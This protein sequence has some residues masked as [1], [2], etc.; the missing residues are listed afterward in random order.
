MP[1]SSYHGYIDFQNKTFISCDIRWH[2]NC[3]ASF[4][5]NRNIQYFQSSSLDESKPD[6]ENNTAETRSQSTLFDL[7]LKCMFC[8]FK[9]HKKDT[10]LIAVQYE[11]VI[12]SIEARCNELQDDSLKR[13][14]GYDFSKLPALEAKYHKNCYLSY[15][16]STETTNDKSTVHDICFSKLVSEI[17]NDLITGRALSVNNLLARYKELLQEEEYDGFDSYTSQK[18]KT[19][20]MKYYG[21]TVC[22]TDKSNEKQYVYNSNLS[23]ADALNV[24]ATYKEQLKDGEIINTADLSPTKILEL[25]ADILKSEIDKAIGISIHPL[26]PDVITDDN[27]NAMI[28]SLLQKFLVLLC[29]CKNE[30]SNSKMW[31]IAQDIITLHSGGKKRMPKN[32]ALGIA[33]KNTL[34]SKEFISYLNNLGHSISYDDVLRIETTWASDIIDSGAGF[35]TIPH[36]IKPNIFTQA[37]SDNADYGQENTSQHVTNTVLY[38]YQMFPGNFAN[39]NMGDKNKQKLRLRR[40]I[41]LPDSPMEDLRTFNNASLPM[42]Y[43][44]INIDDFFGNNADQ[45]SVY[46]KLVTSSW[47]LLRITSKKIFVIDCPQKIPGWTGF[48]KLFSINISKPTVIG[49]CRTIPASPTDINVVHTMMVNVKKMLTSL[50]QGDPCLTVDE[51]IYQ[52]AKQV[53]WCTPFLQDMTIRLGGFHRAKNFLGIIGK[54]MRSTGLLNYLVKP[55]LKVSSCRYQFPSRQEP[56]Q[57]QQNNIRTTF[58]RLK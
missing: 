4:V 21:S 48:K 37:A 47:L 10:R 17:D 52:L 2:K 57:S 8:G 51:S 40:S 30:R 28:P 14:I 6:E 46:S 43:S 1:L 41:V 54:R 49:N 18:L 7:K 9:K 36:N 22:F 31:S 44:K 45:N 35:A 15:F 16:K 24:A 50:G 34:R 27:I 25:A 19:R 20:I 53:Q 32:V 23:I 11:K 12:R 55:K 13:K 42:S 5:S 26:N 58:I 38:Q 33:M 39:T 56:V 3:Y 29:N